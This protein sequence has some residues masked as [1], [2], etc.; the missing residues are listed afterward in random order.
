MLQ[1]LHTTRHPTELNNSAYPDHTH[2]PIHYRLTPSRAPFHADPVDPHPTTT[3]E[4]EKRGHGGHQGAS[5]LSGNGD[6]EGTSPPHIIVRCNAYKSG[7]T[8][9]TNIV[10]AQ[11]HKKALNLGPRRPSKTLGT[12]K[13]TTT[14]LTKRLRIRS[15]TYTGLA[16]G[17][18]T[19]RT[20]P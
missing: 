3:C 4:V 10:D 18:C 5:E 11:N 7:E 6:R 1:H 8:L 9:C 17:H 12:D 14:Y 2:P 20:R 15:N 13:P 16:T 19:S